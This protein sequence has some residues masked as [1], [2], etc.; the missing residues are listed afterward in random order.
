M[1]GQLRM[2]AYL[3]FHM[4]LSDILSLLSGQETREIPRIPLVKYT[5]GE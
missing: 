2:Y 1:K 3:H 4:R 5:D